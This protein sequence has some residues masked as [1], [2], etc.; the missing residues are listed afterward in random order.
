[1]PRAY[2]SA[3]V[4][5][6]ASR[7]WAT[8]RD[9]NSLPDWHPVVRSSEVEDGLAGD[10][11]GAVRSFVLTDG[12]RFRERLLELSDLT[13]TMVYDFQT[14]PLE[15]TDY[16]ATLRCTSV[17]DGDA[18]FVEWRATFDCEPAAAAELIDTFANAVFKVGLD[19]LQQRFR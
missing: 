1:M 5:A 2:A 18:C 13:M 12:A 19:A 11:V 15:V 3:V 8:V 16:L 9:F 6:S 17:T 4:A 14:S 7:V 10:Q